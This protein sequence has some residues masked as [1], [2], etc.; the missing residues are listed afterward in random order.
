MSR[1]Q[2]CYL[3]FQDAKR[4]MIGVL[5]K[6]QY[7]AKAINHIFPGFSCFVI[8]NHDPDILEKIQPLEYVNFVTIETLSSN[9]L[10][11][12]VSTRRKSIE[13]AEKVLRGKEDQL[14][15]IRYPLGCPWMLAFF[16][17]IKA[18]GGRIITEH[19]SF[20]YHELLEQKKYHLALSELL[21]GN[22]CLHSV[23][24]AVGVTREIAQHEKRR[25]RDL[26]V[27]CIPNGINTANYPLKQFSTTDH[28]ICLKLLFVGGVANWHGIDRLIGGLA[29]T[30]YQQIE[31]HVVGEGSELL[32]LKQMV[33]KNNLDKNV[34]F[35]GFQTGKQLNALFDL[36]H[37][38]I[39]S[40]GIHR[41]GLTETSELKA[42]EYCARGIP[43]ICSSYDSD[44]PESFPYR[45]QVPAD[46][47]PINIQ[48][49]LTFTEKVFSVKDPPDK[50]RTFAIQNLDWEVK[51]GKLKLFIDDLITGGHSE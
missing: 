7:Q 23:Y 44:F 31:F 40:L 48:E 8:G 28:R 25:A 13:A 24:G 19:Q 10:A 15:Y 45:L 51:V 3:V 20:E 21:F 33:H 38:A 29:R 27:T 32:K 11:R 4:S 34:F 36:C 43:Y 9:K 2:L 42:R 41:K 12:Q 26:Q 46:D 16:K 49:I 5:K 47:N 30:N 1:N 35:H 18:K 50:M 37:I 22:L 14:F 39:G 6:I 17:K